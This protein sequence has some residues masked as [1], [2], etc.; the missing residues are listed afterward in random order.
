VICPVQSLSQKYSCFRQTLITSISPPSRPGTRGVSRSSRTRDGMRW[1]WQRRARNG[2]AGRSLT[3]RERSTGA[4]TNGASTPSSKLGG[5]HMAG[6]SVWRRLL[7]TAKPCGPGT[8][9]WCQAGG[10]FSSPTGIRRA[11]FASDGDKTNS[12]PGR[13]RR[14]PLKPL[15][16]ECRV[17]RGTCGDYRVLTTNAHG[18][19][20]QRAPGISLRPLFSGRT[21]CAQLGRTAPREF[22]CCFKFES[23][24]RSQRHCERCDGQSTLFADARRPDCV[25]EP[26]ITTRAQ[27]RSS[28]ARIRATSWLAMTV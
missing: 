6:R 20:V 22:F 15:R 23:G 8:R 24:S 12:S 7:R 14:K 17:F 5:R 27:L 3:A 1:T 4:R 11:I 28:R 26:V 18:L 2:I 25:T 10:G 16:R 21:V 19:R 13:A 9:C